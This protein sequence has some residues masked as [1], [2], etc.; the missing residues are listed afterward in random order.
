MSA[1]SDRP[2]WTARAFTWWA[3]HPAAQVTVLVLVSVFAIVG[4]RN[5]SVLSDHLVPLLESLSPV[6]EE[7]SDEF[8]ER[9][10][11]NYLDAAKPPPSNVRG[12]QVGGGDCVLV[13][14][15]ESDEE[16]FFTAQRLGVLREVADG[17]EALPQVESNLWLDS[18]PEFNLFGLTGTLLPSEN[19]S[20]RQIDD[21]RKRVLDNPLAVGQ[22][23]SPDARTI[24]F[25][26]RVD[27]FYVT[28]D[29]DAT[30]AIRQRAEEIAA[31][32]PGAKFGF[33]LTGPVPLHLMVVNNHVTDSMKYQLIGYSI[34]LISAL[35]L[36]RGFSAVII[37]ALAPAVGVFWTMGLLRFAD[38]QDN[39]FNDIIVPVLIS[40]VGLTDAVHLMVEIRQQRAS[41]LDTSQAARRG[42]ARVGLACLLTSV[43]TA[44][45]FLSLMTAH[46]EIVREFGWCC[47]VGIAMTFISVL[48][49]IPLGCRSPLGKRLHVGIGKSL[50]DGQLRR[51]GPLVDWVLRRDRRVAVAAIVAT[52]V[53]GVISLQ[54]TPDEKRY[55]GL[56]ESGEAAKAL[57]HLDDSLGGLEFGYVS[58]SWSASAQQGELLDVLSEVN[59]VLQGE[60]LIGHPLSL[61]QLLTALPGEGEPE[62]RMSLLELLPPELKRSFY[63]PEYRTASVQFRIKDLGIAAYSDTFTRI[64]TRLDQMMTEHPEF[65]APTRWRC[66][67]ALDQRLSDRDR[68]R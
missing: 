56:S 33:Q 30:T 3:D 38:L 31:R 32:T 9:L 52:L 13:V 36:F 16:D 49:V 28:E 21:A 53:L 19:A 54:L 63:V 29:S 62:E 65:F 60:P 45:G 43:T 6:E 64:E 40:L 24:L 34:M 35:V 42:I 1:E 10:N 58:V 25:H 57:R 4:Y 27:W 20:Q 8:Q 66:G 39:P 67:L 2:S 46:H 68:S 41:G 14:T 7:G 44:I 47:V 18:V 23:I 61:H 55:S 22:L 11:R 37:V 5:P 12:F 51:I 17:L 50:V 48:T 15:V 26:L 59:D